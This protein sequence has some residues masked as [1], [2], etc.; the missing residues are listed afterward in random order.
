MPLYIL[1]WLFFGSLAG[2]IAWILATAGNKKRTGLAVY[3]LIGAVGTVLGGILVQFLIGQ[4]EV[5]EVG[6][7][8]IIFAIPFGMIVLGL[9]S[10]SSK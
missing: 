5:S 4:N 6:L 3:M 2:W 10:Y 8:N 1:V 9:F 7:F